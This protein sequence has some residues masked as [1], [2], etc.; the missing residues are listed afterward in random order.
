MIPVSALS[1]YLYCPKKLYLRYVL[2]FIPSTNKFMIK[3]KIKHDVFDA[4]SKNEENMILNIKPSDLDNLDAVYKQKYK[5]LLTKSVSKFEGDIKKAGLDKEQVFN[6]SLKK[7]LD[8]ASYRAKFLSGIIKRTGLFGGDLFAALP[9]K[10]KS[11]IFLSSK[12][13]KIRGIIDKVEIVDGIHIPI[14]LKTGSMPNEGVWPGHKI[15]LASYILLL[16]EKFDCNHGFVDYLDYDVRRKIVMNPFLETEVKDLI[17]NVFDVLESDKIPAACKNL[18]K[19]K[20]CN[21]RESC[22]S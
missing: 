5:D 11:E 6:D 2:K 16:G 20:N 9:V 21:F 15:Q 12:R 1:E 13:L 18:N 8:E 7:F 3:G 17:S 22:F 19:C 4:V 14:E 10:A